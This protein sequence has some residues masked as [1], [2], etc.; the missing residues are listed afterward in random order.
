MTAAEEPDLC[1]VVVGPDGFACT[2]GE[3]RFLVV[4]L[5]GAART[6]APRFEGLAF[7]N[8]LVAI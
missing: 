4:G 7:D 6:E 5:G 1:G 2:T 8:H 3:G